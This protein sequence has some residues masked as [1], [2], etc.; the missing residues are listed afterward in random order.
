MEN[1]FKILELI[2]KTIFSTI[3]IFGG[4]SFLIFVAIVLGKNP[5]FS[6]WVYIIITICLMLFVNWALWTH[7][8]MRKI[9]LW[10]LL[11]ILGMILF[12]ISLTV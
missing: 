9:F 7:G 11:F 8:K 2:A 1:I 10:F 3:V 6:M 12:L 4:I 5:D